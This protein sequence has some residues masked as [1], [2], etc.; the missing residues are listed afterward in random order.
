MKVASSRPITPAER[1]SIR[2]RIE[3]DHTYQDTE[4]MVHWGLAFGMLGLLCSAAV[5]WLLHRFVDTEAMDPLHYAYAMSGIVIVC[6]LTGG[7]FGVWFCGRLGP[8]L[9][10]HGKRLMKELRGGTVQETRYN[11]GN[12][13]R[14]CRTGGAPLGYALEVGDF[15]LL[16]VDETFVKHLIGSDEFPNRSIVL[17][18]TPI[19]GFV[20]GIRCDG[21]P[22]SPSGEHV[23][24][25][26]RALPENG[27]LLHGE[28]DEIEKLI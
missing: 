28:L 27:D 19:S 1:D 24:S 16:Y 2:A 14:I 12:S 21:E 23:V 18:E 15:D 17:S 4:R 6:A 25:E 22:C 20:V 7:I 26:G 3:K 10:E 9:D 13:I 5:M 11:V 8:D